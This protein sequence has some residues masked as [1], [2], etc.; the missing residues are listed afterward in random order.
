MISGIT[1]IDFY[2]RYSLKEFFIKRFNKIVI[3]FLAWSIIILAGKVAAHRIPASEINARYI[4]QSI[5]GTTIVDYYWFF[6]S[7]FLIYLSMPLFA[8]VNKDKRKEVFTYLAAAGFLLNTLLPF[9]NGVFELELNTPYA[10]IVD[11][12]VLIWVPLGWLLHNTQFRKWQK[13]VIYS[14]ALCGLLLHIVGTYVLSMGADMIDGT[15]KGYE[16]VPSILYAVGV[17]VLLK[18]IGTKVM[19]SRTQSFFSFLGGYTYPIFL[20]Q[21]IFLKLI[22]QLPFVN[23]KSLVYRLGGPYVIIPMII[24][25]TAVLRKIP[26]VKKIV[27]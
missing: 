20:T 25:M 8:A 14:L 16:N 21:F 4:Y 17:F 3:P 5:T 2:D 7:L 23:P 27:P 12:N 1:L 22:V 11:M 13:A 10:V 6:S 19:E 15:F 9:I 18:D 26:I 24:A